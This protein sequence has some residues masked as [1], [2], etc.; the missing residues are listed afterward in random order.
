MLVNNIIVD[1]TLANLVLVLWANLFHGVVIT[2]VVQSKDGHYCD[3]YPM[4][5]F[6]PLAI[7]VFGCLH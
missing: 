1:P 2:I 7:K 4:D 5:Q 3:R 6:L